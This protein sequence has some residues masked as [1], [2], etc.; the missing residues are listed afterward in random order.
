[1]PF[2]VLLN[3]TRTFLPLSAVIYINLG[4]WKNSIKIFHVE[5]QEIK[6]RSIA[7]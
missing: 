4:R 5:K 6:T 7:I 3:D 1:M 2:H